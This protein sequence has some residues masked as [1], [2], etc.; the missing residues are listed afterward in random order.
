MLTAIIVAAALT[1]CATR[2]KE[3]ES[4]HKTVGKASD[5]QGTIVGA[6]LRCQGYMCPQWALD[7]SRWAVTETDSANI[8]INLAEL[9]PLVLHVL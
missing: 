2:A 6:Q 5:A 8:E 7:I 9:L 3:N 4:S 1:I